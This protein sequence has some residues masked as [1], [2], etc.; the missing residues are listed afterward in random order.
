LFIVLFIVNAA[1]QPQFLAQQ[2]A[3]AG[4]FRALDPGRARTAG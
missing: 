1:V 4:R 2:G 3:L